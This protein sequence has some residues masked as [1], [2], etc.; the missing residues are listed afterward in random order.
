MKKQCSTSILIVILLFALKAVAIIKLPPILS[1]N[2]VLQQNS[3]TTLWGWSDPSERFVIISSWKTEADTIVALNTGKWKAKID[4]PKAGGPYT[5]T[6]KGRRN[7]IVLE[8]ILIGEVWILSGQSNMEMSNNQQIKD[9]LPKSANTNIRFFTV[10]KKTS[11]HPQD[12]AEGQWVSC[13]E[14]TL[15]RF[16]AAGYFFGK[17]L[18]DD[19]NV[20]IGLIQS[21]W[22]GTPIELWEP[23]SV[24]ESDPI[25]KKAA[26]E[27]VVKTHR[28]HQPGYI[29]N[30]MIYPIS[31]YTIAGALW[32]QGESNT[33]RAY[34]Y[35]KMLTSMIGAWRKQFE[36]EFP[37]YYVQIAPWT[38][39]IPSFEGALLMEAQTK[40]LSYPKTGM[41]VIT[42]LVDDVTNLHPQNKKDVGERLAL[43]ALAETY[44]KNIPV[45]K[46]PILTTMKI[47]KGK[48]NLYF[49]DAPNGFIT[50]DGG[51]P[52]EFMIAGSDKKFLPAE[53]KIEKDK[54]VVSNKN[55]KEPVAVRFS[56]RNAGISNVLSKEGFPITPFRTDNWDLIAESN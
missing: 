12:Y 41:V 45:H 25:M 13:D 48:A 56:F 20:P 23:E 30:A 54:I 16:S 47:D 46:S 34:A 51:K 27:I 52:T 8:N 9:I 17:K 19:L 36:Q 29:Y 28:A 35:E 3:K 1:S 53:V 26:S 38:Y 40:A 2:M 32:Y 49:S 10:D 55:I 6:I 50:K 7:T 43:L 24:I 31:N 33:P 15:K 4:T 39:E 14:E 5:I 22:A 11:E 37:F 21:A 42:D 18:H 44:G